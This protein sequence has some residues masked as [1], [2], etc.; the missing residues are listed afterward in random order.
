[1]LPEQEPVSFKDDGMVV[2]HTV[3]LSG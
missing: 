3:M 2:C 1:L